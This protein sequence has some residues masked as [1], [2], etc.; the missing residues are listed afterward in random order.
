MS[1]NGDEPDCGDLR[2]IEDIREA[3]AAYV[4][5]PDRIMI[6]VGSYIRIARHAMTKRKFRRWRGWFDAKVRAG[7]LG[8]DG[9]ITW[10]HPL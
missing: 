1:D 5:T 2:V 10:E 9:F 8:A 4:A 6:G 3:M 7:R